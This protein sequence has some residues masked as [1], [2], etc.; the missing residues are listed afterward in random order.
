MKTGLRST[1]DVRPIITAGREP[2]PQIQQHIS[3]LKPGQTLV[4]I[5]PFM[6]AP[7]I[8]LMKNQGFTVRSLPAG[9]GSWETTLVR[10]LD[11]RSPS[12]SA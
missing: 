10:P 3:D 2:F 7:L 1:L 4:V 11:H 8:E 9:D 6:P 12:G 5:S